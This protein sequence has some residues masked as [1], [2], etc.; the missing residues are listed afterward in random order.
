[1]THHDE[2]IACKQQIQLALLSYGMAILAVARVDS[3]MVPAIAGAPHFAL[4]GWD[5]T[6]VSRVGFLA[7]SRGASFTVR[8]DDPITDP[9]TFSAQIWRGGTPKKRARVYD[10]VFACALAHL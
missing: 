4:D 3:D 8:I 2:S 10:V 9:P 1:M 6:V 5:S 7:H